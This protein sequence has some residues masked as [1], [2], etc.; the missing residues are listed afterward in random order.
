[1]R[2]Q[3]RVVNDIGGLYKVIEENLLD[4]EDV[5]TGEEEN[6]SVTLFTGRLADCESFIRL[7]KEGYM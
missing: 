7:T 3:I 1:M 6:Y 4:E 2:K 5:W